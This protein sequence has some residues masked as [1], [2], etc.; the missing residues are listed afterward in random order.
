MSSIVRAAALMAP[1]AVESGVAGNALQ[2]AG[3]AGE[4]FTGALRHLS[5]SS[6]RAAGYR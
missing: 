5:W 1:G 2:H 6:H 3:R 4:R